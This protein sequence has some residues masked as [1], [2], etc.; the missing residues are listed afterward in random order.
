MANLNESDQWGEGIYQ[1]EEDDPVLGGPTG[2]DNR[3]PRE[4]ANR[5]RYQRLRNV[6]PWDATLSY[7]ANV[8]YVSYGGTTW[9]SVGENLNV[10][11]GSDPAKWV[12][13]GFT[14]AEL[15]DALG[16]AVEV[17]EAKVD[18]HPQYVR[19]DAPQGLSGAAATRARANIGVEAAG[20]AIGQLQ[21]NAPKYAADTGAVNAV[22]VAFA[23]A[24]TEVT[25]GMDLWFKA[26]VTNTG[27]A[28]LNVNGLG[29]LPILGA[30]HVPLEGGEIVAGGKCLVVASESHA[31]WL[32]IGCTGGAQQVGAATKSQ[33]AVQFGRSQASMPT[34]RSQPRTPGWC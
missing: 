34:W 13:W 20:Y 28:T 22:V 7:P 32:L 15:G 21:K 14:A 10:A 4:L 3:A 19:H 2:I 31:A 1:L 33:H 23:P 26:K 25:D 11:P 27:P 12:R 30:G 29:A 18:P 16:D 9:K 6:T 5:S 8:A 24:V 17:H